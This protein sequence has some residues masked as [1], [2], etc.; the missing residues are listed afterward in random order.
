MW[1]SDNKLL[2]I[3]SEPDWFGGGGTN[4]IFVS[5]YG[6]PE[7]LR[8]VLELDNNE[9]LDGRIIGKVHFEDRKL[10]FSVVSER[11]WNLETGQYDTIENVRDYEYDAESEILKL[12][13]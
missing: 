1:S 11:D 10:F 6:K 12:L 4:G 9:S 2:A 8:L 3:V 13:D 7:N 5:E